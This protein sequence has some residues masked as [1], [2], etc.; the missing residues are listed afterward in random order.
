[1]ECIYVYEIVTKQE[2]I[3]GILEFAYLTNDG[4]GHGP[5]NYSIKNKKDV[6][7]TNASFESILLKKVNEEVI[8]K[9]KDGAKFFI[10]DMKK[11]DVKEITFL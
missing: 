7:I 4:F 11:D 1:M 3:T 5:F 8:E 2:N 9:L 6:K 10:I